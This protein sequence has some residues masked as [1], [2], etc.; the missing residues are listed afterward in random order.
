MVI[1]EGNDA[2]GC[3][4]SGLKR[5]DVA[6]RRSPQPIGR[7][8]RVQH[9]LGERPALL[10]RQLDRLHVLDRTDGRCMDAGDHE[11][12]QGSPLELSRAKDEM[13]SMVSHEMRTPLAS[14][15]GFTDD[16]GPEKINQILAVQRAK[17]VEDYIL[18]FDLAQT[19]G[20]RHLFAFPAKLCNVCI[21]LLP[22]G[23]HR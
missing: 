23:K 7:L 22:A 5:V 8:P 17:A 14:I 13:V 18:I 19:F 9:R 11:I 21:C 1:V 20:G 6:T 10:L 16:S 3:R 15:V 4:G 2:H 12:G